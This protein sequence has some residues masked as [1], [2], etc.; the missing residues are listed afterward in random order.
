MAKSPVLDPYGR[1][2]D[3]KALTEEIAAAS[4]GS[5]RSPVSGYPGDGLD[6]VRLANILRAADQGDPVRY[7]ELAETIEERDLHYLGVVGTRKRAV[8]QLPATVTTRGTTA[9]EKKHADA[10]RD[11][12]TRDELQGELFDILDAVGK[13]YSFTEIIWE[14]A[15][16]MTVPQRLE[17]RDPRW[18]RFQRKD[19]RTPVMLNEGGQEEPL[20]AYKFIFAPI[21]AKSGLPVRGGLA[22]PAAWAWMFKAFTQRDWAIFTQTYGQPIRVGKYGPGT[23]EEEKDTLYHAVVNIAGD[24]A[25]IMPDSMMMEFIEAQNISGSVDLYERRADWL[26]K[27]TSK[28][29]LGQTSTTDAVTGGL[30]SGKEHRQVQE[31]IETADAGLLAGVLNQMLVRPFVDLNFGPQKRYPQL[32]LARPEAEDLKAWTD[33]AT[34]WVEVGLQVSE[35][36]VL[37]KLG[38]SAPKSGERILGKPPETPP[39]PGLQ[40][41]AGSGNTPESIFKGGFNTRNG[42][43][44][45]DTALQAEQPSTGD[46]SG[47]SPIPDLTARLELEAGPAVDGMLDQIEAM[48]GAASSFEEFREILLNAYSD[49]DA[50]GL[51][52]SLTDAITAAAAGGRAAAEDEAGD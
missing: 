12:L 16:G 20:P 27:Q 9:A 18:F 45:G 3:R 37:A 28:A 35:K 10:F 11:W 33:A 43:S 36:E 41:G 32:K 29:V 26:D 47:V 52:V 15:D 31:D 8:S 30:G 38:L 7:L 13:G 42:N 5:V 39:Q 25:A 4:F 17:W 1:P 44:G 6:P 21:K 48:F 22:R 51:T 46:F 50:S 23:S 19:L 2:V 24:C 34:P 40:P 49:L 14:H